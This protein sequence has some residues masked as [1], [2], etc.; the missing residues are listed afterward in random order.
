MSNKS[1]EQKRE[2]KRKRN[3]T[4]G[5]NQKE[6]NKKISNALSYGYTTGKLEHL[7]EATAARMSE[8]MAGKFSYVDIFADESGV[9]DI[10]DILSHT[11]KF[12]I[13]MNFLKDKHAVVEMKR[14]MAL[15]FLST[16]QYTPPN[17]IDEKNI[18]R[19]VFVTVCRYH[20]PDTGEEN[21]FVYGHVY[22][23]WKLGKLPRVGK[24]RRVKEKKECPLCKDMIVVGDAY[25]MHVSSCNGVR[26][27]EKLDR[28]ECPHCGFVGPKHIVSRYHDNHCE[29]VTGKKRPAKQPVKVCPHC[30]RT[31]AAGLMTRYHFNNCKHKPNEGL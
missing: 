22:P 16:E 17:D 15:Y 2:I 5:D 13:R 11:R 25:D 28:R 12:P 24:F 1:P 10:S 30:G 19:D 20:N 29:V 7:R 6:I 18:V 31:G 27:V 8:A 3:E 9:S 14:N 21:L 26:I 4:V 23:G